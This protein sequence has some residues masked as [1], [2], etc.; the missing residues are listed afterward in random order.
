MDLNQMT[1]LGNLGDNPKMT[2]FDDRNKVV[3]LVVATNSYWKDKKSGEQKE[4]TEWH[5]VY[6][7]GR[8]AEVAQ[9]Y[10]QK[11]NKVYIRGKMRTRKYIN[12]KQETHWVTEIHGTQMFMVSGTPVKKSV[13]ENTVL[14]TE[15]P[16]QKD[17]LEQPVVE[18]GVMGEG[19]IEESKAADVAPVIE[20]AVIDKEVVE[21]A[22]VADIA[23]AVSDS[24][25]SDALVE[26]LSVE[27]VIETE[28]DHGSKEDNEVDFPAVDDEPPADDEWIMDDLDDALDIEVDCSDDLTDE[29]NRKAQA[30]AEQDEISGVSDL[31]DWLIP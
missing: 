18:P 11:G 27:P 7:R 29:F 26:E 13:V 14:N 1:I 17:V 25:A 16:T 15:S 19:V 6:L 10:L 23:P 31:P 28:I 12:D 4:D 8:M 24:V 22:E 21:E 3:K 30:A 9:E 20:P 2:I 5:T